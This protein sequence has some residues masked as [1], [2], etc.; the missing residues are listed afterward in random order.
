MPAYEGP[1]LTAANLIAIFGFTLE[2]IRP[3]T[4]KIK[5]KDGQVKIRLKNIIEDANCML[6]FNESLGD[7]GWI[8][9]FTFTHEDLDENG[10]V[11]HDKD[12]LSGFFRVTLL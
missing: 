12:I 3:V 9:V 8:N 10:A 4:A 7:D 6:Q 2:D 11:S 1:Q 5:L